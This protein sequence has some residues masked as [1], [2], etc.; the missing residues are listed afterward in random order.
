MQETSSASIAE[1]WV[2]RPS[3]AAQAPLAVG[4]SGGLDSTVLLHLLAHDPTQRATG[5]RALHIDHGLHADASRWAAHAEATC[6]ALGIESR[7][8][9]VAVPRDSSLGPEAAARH[10]R[11]TAFAAALHRGEVLALAQHLDDQAETF[12]LRALRA[13]GVDGLAAMRPWREFAAGWLWRPLLQ[14]PRRALLTYAERH[15]LSWVE[16]PSNRDTALDRNFLRHRVL[17]VLRE[18]WPHADAALARSATLAAEASDLL[19]EQ[20]AA[21]LEQA[22][23][24]DP[25]PS[26]SAVLSRTALR[27]LP[28][29]RRARV[30]RYWT[31]LCGAPP[32]PA[33]G[34]AR[35][36]SDLLD[37]ENDRLPAFAWHGHE[38]V[39][40]R[41]HLYCFDARERE[42]HALPQDFGVRWDGSSPLTLPNGDRLEVIGTRALP[43]PVRVHARVGGERI[44]LPHRDHRHALKHVLQDH[45]VPPWER[46][47][48]PL[49]S[50]ED[51]RLMAAGGRI[52]ASELAEWLAETG[53]ELRWLRAGTPT[54]PRDA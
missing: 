11:R 41:D 1:R 35:I 3:E 22:R 2:P 26:S 17:P 30:L 52:V 14:T 25:D 42:A 48:M 31:R 37:R 23:S 36:E 34:V 15:G 19:D 10:A 5:L 27:A 44:R 39:A 49:L 13:S 16:D 50:H 53:A 32:L 40:W 38:I 29:A 46:A 6:R 33:E 51:G 9:A 8:I 7:T 20:D 18:R 21:A 24:N 47:R 4:F 12:L 28:A 43:W 45:D 54:T